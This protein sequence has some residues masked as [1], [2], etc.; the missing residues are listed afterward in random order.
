MIKKTKNRRSFLKYTSLS[1]LS[2][3][4]IPT[5]FK[6]NSKKLINFKSTCNPTT[7]DAYG[8]GPFYTPNAPNIIN[9]QLAG[10][11]EIGTRMI[12]SGQVL[13]LDCSEVI[14]NT[15]IDIWHADNEGMYDNVGFNLR[16]VTSTNSQG[17]YIFETIKPG[18]YLNGSTYRPSHI[19]IKVS[20]PG[21]NS[22]I[23]QLYFQ[24]DPYIPTDGAAS[25]SNGIFDATHRIIPLVLNSNGDLE[26]TWDIV[27]DGNGVILGNSNLHL[28][29]GIIYN[30][31]PNPFRNEIEINYGVFDK[32]K[33]DISVFNINGEKV[34]R[35]DEK[36]L[37]S[38]KYSVKW[39][40]QQNLL[41]GH[42]FIAIIIN[43]LQ[44]H[45]L[46]VQKQ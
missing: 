28:D 5:I 37:D 19:H 36:I 16:G 4:A 32:A 38:G 17:F 25:I 42:Y 35:L 27:V 13:N 31:F 7:E 23:T 30:T 8:Q 40:P 6:A 9:G 20:P 2:L 22:L 1:L 46:K 21:F 11:N 26:G 14:P 33:V 43:D 41:N 39:I 12:I 44:V 3:S 45:Y 29:K 10:V 24:G 15:E 34:A 18:F